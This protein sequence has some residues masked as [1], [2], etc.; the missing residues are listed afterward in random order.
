MHPVGR[1]IHSVT[2]E[3]PWAIA[4][5]SLTACH[6]DQRGQGEEFTWVDSTRKGIPFNLS[7]IITY[8]SQITVKTRLFPLDLKN[9]NDKKTLPNINWCSSRDLHVVNRRTH[10]H[11]S[12]KIK[13][14]SHSYTYS[15]IQTRGKQVKKYPRRSQEWGFCCSRY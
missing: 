10:T 13:P 6:S 5:S 4:V 12:N 1:S 9:L 2:M 7:H 11:K 8:H 15:P 3:Q 14:P